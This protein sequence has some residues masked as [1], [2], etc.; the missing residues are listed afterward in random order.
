MDTAVATVGIIWVLLFLQKKSAAEYRCC[1]IHRRYKLDTVVVAKGSAGHRWSFR[2]DQLDTPVVTGWA[3]G[4][5]DNYHETSCM[6][7][8]PVCY[9]SPGHN[10]KDVG[11]CGIWYIS[12]GIC[13]ILLLSLGIYKI[14]LISMVYSN[15]NNIWFAAFPYLYRDCQ[16]PANLFIE[17][18]AE[19]ISWILL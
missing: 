11:I 16:E 5:C 15:D 4:Y 10:H 6:R 1:Y 17:L 18:H 13:G 2:K 9:K 8:A 12:L 3:A 14:L 7:T 19:E